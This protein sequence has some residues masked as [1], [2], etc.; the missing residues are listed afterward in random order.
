MSSENAHI[1]RSSY[2]IPVVAAHIN[3]SPNAIKPSEHPVLEN[4]EPAFRP[5]AL[6]GLAAIY[7]AGRESPSLLAAPPLNDPSEPPIHPDFIRQA[8][9]LDQESALVAQAGA[10]VLAAVSA[11][12]AWVHHTNTEIT[13]SEPK[14]QRYET[15][16]QQDIK[17]ARARVTG[18]NV[19]YHYGG[20]D[21]EIADL[22]AFHMVQNG[23]AGSLRFSATIL[24]TDDEPPKTKYHYFLNLSTDYHNTSGGGQPGWATARV[25]AGMIDN[26]RFAVVDEDANFDR[27]RRVAHLLSSLAMSEA[28]LA[29]TPMTNYGFVRGRKSP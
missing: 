20:F 1:T 28:T 26:E 23:N 15:R 8:S 12:Q 24:L 25:E 3:N 2:N 9:L 10:T 6:S 18:G 11:Y 4:F 19:L 27:I 7:W 5:L 13:M 21:W 17:E 16:A 22:A 14:Y 29:D